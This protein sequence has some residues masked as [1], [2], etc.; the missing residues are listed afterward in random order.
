[1]KKYRKLLKE[2][3]LKITPK[4]KG[5][6]EFFL[7]NNVY[8]TPE[9]IWKYM[10]KNFNKMGLPTIYRNLAELEKIGVLTK[11]AGEGER[12]YYG[13]CKAEKPFSH[14]HHIVCIYCHKVDI[15]ESCNFDTIK[16]TIEKKTNFKVIDH[17]LQLTGVCGSCLKKRKG[18]IWKGK[19]L[20][21]N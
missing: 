8:S 6:I 3:N 15:V 16:K 19:L 10:K 12:M 21:K 17:K 7:K 18:K 11:I 20:E 14:H 9:D 5:I 4:R 1:M 13:L 2:N